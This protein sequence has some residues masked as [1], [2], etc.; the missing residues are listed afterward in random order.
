M[1]QLEHIFMS[2]S[3]YKAICFPKFK[4]SQE[5]RSLYFLPF[6]PYTRDKERTPMCLLMMLA[7]LPAS[8]AVSLC[9]V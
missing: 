7:A 5:I 8:P 1:K 2:I 6:S 4:L 9:S 3:F